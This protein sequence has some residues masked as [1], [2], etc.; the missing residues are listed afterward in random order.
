MPELVPH[1]APPTA[2]ATDAPSL[3]SG[4]ILLSEDAATRM[5]TGDIL[6]LR[7]FSGELEEFCG[8]Y[9]VAAP[10]G[11]VLGHHPRLKQAQALA[12]TEA[13]AKGIRPGQLTWYYVPTR[14]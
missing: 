4:T 14:D 9:I 6:N 11:T 13:T 5:N 8:E 7:F 1:T 12:A 3:G 10:D 2:P